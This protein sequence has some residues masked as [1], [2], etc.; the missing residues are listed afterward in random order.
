MFGLAPR[1]RADFRQQKTRAKRVYNLV[2]PTVGLFQADASTPI[3]ILSISSGVADAS[4]IRHSCRNSV[5]VMS[6]NTLYSVQCARGLAAF[7]VAIFHMLPIETKYVAQQV[8]PSFFS[9]GQ[10]GVDI[11]F[12][13]SGFV[14]VLTTEQSHQ[15]IGAIGEF[16]RRRATRIFPLYWFYLLLLLPIY[17][18]APQMINSAQGNQVDLVASFLLLPSNKLPLLNV[19]W[20]LVF[21][22]W[23][24]IAFAA[25]LLMPRKWL[26]PTLFGWAALIIANSLHVRSGAS[27]TIDLVLSAYS[28]EFISGAIGCWL[29]PKVS[30]GTARAAIVAGF[31]ALAGTLWFFAAAIDVI[32]VERCIALGASIA[33]VL[34][35]AAAWERH[36]GLRSLSRLK[37]TGDISYSVYLS[38]V[39]VLSVVGRT[40]LLLTDR[41]E[42]GMLATFLF[43]SAA[44]ILVIAAGL[45]SYHLVERPLMG[46]F[47]TR[48][49][50]S[51]DRSLKPLQI[52]SKRYRLARRSIQGPE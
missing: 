26:V 36:G 42:T 15:S 37:W 23:F 20:S 24:Y 51:T 5:G 14:M 49:V 22:L 12:V 34:T 17:F 2:W 40:W 33:L 46:F 28:L 27:P 9:F 48:K 18:A 7:M 35:G 44:G 25:I 38:H 43:W 21:E 41:A 13:I 19:G 16:I 32:S 10:I 3:P 45:F 39:L 47:N 52:P 31:A 30:L 29:L 8:L 1:P 50:S 11:F 4:K 6:N